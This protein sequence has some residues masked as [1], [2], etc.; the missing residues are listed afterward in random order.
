[1]VSHLDNEYSDNLAIILPD[2]YLTVIGRVCVQW[3]MLETIFEIA[4]RKL[5]GF[6][7]YDPRPF[8]FTTHMAWPLKMDILATLVDIYRTDYPHLAEF[9]QIV[10]LLKKAQSGR[11]RI[12]HASWSYENGVVNI[13]RGTARGKLKTSVEMITIPE[14]EAIVS[15]IGIAGARLLKMILNKSEIDS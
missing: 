3:A 8:I 12:I 11:N 13:L 5:A 15:D 7:D 6:D 2:S 4:L 1:M 9:D 14:I 10:P